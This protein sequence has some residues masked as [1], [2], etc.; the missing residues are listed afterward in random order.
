MR[1]M[2]ISGPAGVVVV[3]ITI[4]LSNNFDFHMRR[5][6]ACGRKKAAVE[7]EMGSPLACITLT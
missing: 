1:I 2:N 5:R 6:M 3:G 4:L 7:R